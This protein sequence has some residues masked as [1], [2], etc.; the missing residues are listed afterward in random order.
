MVFSQVLLLLE[1][2]GVDWYDVQKVTA[3]VL[4]YPLYFGGDICNTIPD[5]ILYKIC[6]ENIQTL[7]WRGYTN[8]Y[9][10]NR[11]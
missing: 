4:E 5:D 9:K 1:I 8:H 10:G 7:V 2:T 6:Y 11:S 3:V